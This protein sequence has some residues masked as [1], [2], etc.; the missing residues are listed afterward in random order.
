M[1]NAASGGKAPMIA[2]GRPDIPDMLRRAL[3]IAG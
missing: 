3:L 1:I 2:D